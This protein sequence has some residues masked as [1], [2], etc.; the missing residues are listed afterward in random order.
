MLDRYYESLP[1]IDYSSLGLSTTT[2]NPTQISLQ[3]FFSDSVL[4]NYLTMTNSFIAIVNT[5]ELFVSKTTLNKSRI[6]GVYLAYNDPILPMALSS[7]RVVE[8]WKEYDD[9]QWSLNVVDSLQNNRIFDTAD[10]HNFTS[11]SNQRT[12][13]K[14]GENSAAYLLEIGKDF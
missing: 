6:P 10:K 13:F 4:I 14:T 2:N 5:P 1:Y 7:G 12:P 9:Q 3:Q 11:V 8:Y